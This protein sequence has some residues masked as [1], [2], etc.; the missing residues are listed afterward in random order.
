MGHLKHRILQL[1]LHKVPLANP[2]EAFHLVLQNTVLIYGHIVRHLC[3][4]LKDAVFRVSH[5]Q[6]TA[7]P[8]CVTATIARARRHFWYP[9]MNVETRQSCVICMQK[10]VKE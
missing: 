1:I 4:A 9:G 5:E 6:P 10:L 2:Q 3:I 7:G 8:F